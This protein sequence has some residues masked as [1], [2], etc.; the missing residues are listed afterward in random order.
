MV[1][2]LVLI[3]SYTVAILLNA[4]RWLRGHWSL[5][6]NATPTHKGMHTHT[7]LPGLGKLLVPQIYTDEAMMHA[8]THRSVKSHTKNTQW[9]SNLREL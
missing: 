6:D 8:Y 9:E 3:P 1:L 2:T 4:P 5:P 7:G